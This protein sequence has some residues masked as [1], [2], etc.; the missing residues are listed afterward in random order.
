MPRRPKS[1]N[2]LLPEAT[3]K[4]RVEPYFSVRVVED[5]RH[6]DHSTWLGRTAREALTRAKRDIVLADHTRHVKL[7]VTNGKLIHAIG[8]ANPTYPTEPDE[9][10]DQVL[11]ITGGVLLE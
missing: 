2:P 1:D 8:W 10:I 7:F 3:V 9:L 6:W 11:A 5:T 4:V